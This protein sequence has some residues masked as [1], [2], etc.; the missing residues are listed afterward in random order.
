MYRNLALALAIFGSQTAAFPAVM[1]ALENREAKVPSTP[2]APD[3]IK[4][5]NAKQQYISTSGEHAFKMP[6]LAAGDQVNL[7]LLA[8]NTGF[9]C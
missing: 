4:R 5:F 7:D 3:P 2:H 1:E 8:V 9:R 6:D